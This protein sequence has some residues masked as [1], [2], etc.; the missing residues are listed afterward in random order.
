[1]QNGIEL[2]GKTPLQLVGNNALA[3]TAKKMALGLGVRAIAA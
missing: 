1:M 3:F 2:R